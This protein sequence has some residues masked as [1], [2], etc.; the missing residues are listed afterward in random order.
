MGLEVLPEKAGGSVSMARKR[1][2]IWKAWQGAKRRIDELEEKTEEA[3]KRKRDGAVDVE[4]AELE[5]K[6]TKGRLGSRGRK[7]DK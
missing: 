2:A 4:A 3:E 5:P 7:G 6:K 1:E